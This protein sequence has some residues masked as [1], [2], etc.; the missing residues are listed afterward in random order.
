M[1]ITDYHVLIRDA[2]RAALQAATDALATEL[3]APP[4]PWHAVDELDDAARLTRP[5]GVVCCVGPEQ[6]RPEFGTNRQ[7]GRGYPVAVMLLGS[8]KSHGEKRTGP[9]DLTGFRRLVTTSLNRQRLAG[10]AQV[11]VC[12]VGDSGPIVDEKAP[13]FQV[14][15]TAL[16]V[17]CVG[18][19]PRA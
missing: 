14:L 10:V 19:F 12:E 9:T 16:V 5:C 4:L 2:V 18:R 6:E 8:G 3:A 7:D 1:P 11:A 15:A 17:N 13:L